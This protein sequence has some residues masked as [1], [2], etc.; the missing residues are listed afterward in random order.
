MAA[1]TATEV[2]GTGAKQVTVT[3]LGAS[4]TLTYNLGVQATL[5]LNNVTVGALTPNIDGDEATTLPVRGYGSVDVS[6]GYTTDSIAA[7]EVYVLELDTIKEFLK[8][9]IT[10]T[11]GSGI[12]AILLEYK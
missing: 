10:V 7:G 8:G 4:D 11:G 2:Q 3:T 1:I 6:G 9:T 5:I 12:E